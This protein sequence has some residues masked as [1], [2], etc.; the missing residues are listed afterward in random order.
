MKYVFICG[1]FTQ[2]AKNRKFIKSVVAFKA[3]S[4]YLLVNM[5]FKLKKLKE[6]K[7]K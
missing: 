3:E 2:G 4:L 5:L 1:D 7:F 6:I